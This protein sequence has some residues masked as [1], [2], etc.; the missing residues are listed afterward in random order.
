MR[1]RDELAR[2]DS[3][4]HQELQR[5]QTVLQERARR[6]KALEMEL[7]RLK[8]PGPVAGPTGGAASASGAVEDEVE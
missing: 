6:E 4:R 1:F 7:A 8:R 2:R 5:L 3:L